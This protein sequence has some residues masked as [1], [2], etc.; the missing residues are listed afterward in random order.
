MNNKV[1]YVQALACVAGSASFAWAGWTV[2]TA[3]PTG[4]AISRAHA[5]GGA[6]V[7]GRLELIATGTGISRAGFLPS[8]VTT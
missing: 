3:H 2:T 7:G 5:A 6:G 1:M 8:S 4:G